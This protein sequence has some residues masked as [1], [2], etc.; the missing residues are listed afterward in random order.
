MRQ[1]DENGDETA[2]ER[3]EGREEEKTDQNTPLTPQ[4]GERVREAR[5][6]S[7]P[8]P[9]HPRRR[10]TDLAP[11]LPDL[12]AALAEWPEFP[13]AWA[14]WLEYR[15]QRKLE[16]VA[17]TAAAQLERLLEFKGEGYDP[18]YV[19]RE[20]I[21][22]AWRGVFR[23]RDKTGGPPPNLV[24]DPPTPDPDAATPTM[25]ELLA[26]VSAEPSRRRP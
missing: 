4:G 9:P 16:T 21:A 6:G 24:L 8:T 23:P 5:E 13:A 11:P 3:R 22:H 18:A 14:D 10:R 7:K 17:A 26:A 20:C 1:D 15:R 19:L 12:P 25:A 2:P